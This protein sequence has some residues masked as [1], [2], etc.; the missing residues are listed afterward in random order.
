MN[1]YVT[2]FIGS[3]QTAGRRRSPLTLES[4]ERDLTQ[5][6]AYVKA[7]G[8]ERVQDIQKHHLSY[9]FLRLKQQ[10]RSSATISR[11][12][13][14]A[15]AFFHYLLAGGSIAADPAQHLEAPKQEKRVPEA[16]T[17]DEVERLLAAPDRTSQAGMRDIAMLE[18]LY[19]T[20]MRVSELISLDLE[21]VQLMLGFIRCIDAKAKE[22]IIPLGGAASEALK[23]YLTD[24]RPRLAKDGGQALFVNLQ[25]S[26]MT[27]QGFWKIIK[28]HARE[29]GIE[30]DLAPHSLRHAF[31]SHLLQNGA[32]LHSV[33]EMMG[34]AGLQTT[35][36][37][38][39]QTKT[40]IKDVYDLAHPRAKRQI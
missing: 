32:D 8:I 12:M 22:R 31:A 19:A 18:L 27:R 37:Y 1:E 35:Q 34:H 39:Q 14:S 20:G 29:A 40:R 6:L 25:G 4:Y 9:Y 7:E 2:A 13:V 16:L 26:R 3:L 36:L 21:H 33:Q 24:I 28:K 23:A 15:R 11:Q 5:L 10:G 30:S 38:V 17:L